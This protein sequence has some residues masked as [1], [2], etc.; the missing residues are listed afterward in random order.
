[1]RGFAAGV[2]S[3]TGINAAALIRR[4]TMGAGPESLWRRSDS[5]L[6]NHESPFF[7]L[8]LFSI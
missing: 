2:G 7:D 5:H 4:S 3:R 6:L 1:M 8:R